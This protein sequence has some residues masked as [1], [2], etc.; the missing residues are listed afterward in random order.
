MTCEILRHYHGA[1]CECRTCGVVFDAKSIRPCRRH[2]LPLALVG[3]PLLGL[4][5]LVVL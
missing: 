2:L 1:V 4:L 5:A 3:L